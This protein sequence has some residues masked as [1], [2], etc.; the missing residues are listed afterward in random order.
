MGLFPNTDFPEWGG[1]IVAGPPTLNGGV[2]ELLAMVSNT[3]ATN[4]PYPT[5]GVANYRQ[6]TVNSETFINSVVWSTGVNVPTG[7]TTVEIAI[8]NE[9]R[10]Q[11]TTTGTVTPATPSSLQSAVFSP[12]VTLKTGC[13]YLAWINR[14]WQTGG[15]GITPFLGTPALNANKHRAMGIFEQNVGISTALPATATFSPVSI[16]AAMGLPIMAL[17]GRS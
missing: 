3:F 11:L 9:N 14:N 10:Q 5:Q 4:I 17:L 8:Y 6:F 15:A 2:L 1:P 13:Y 12:T 16:N 7:T